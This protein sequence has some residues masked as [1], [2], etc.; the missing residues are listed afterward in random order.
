M[1]R[2]TTRTGLSVTATRLDKTYRT[3]VKV[4]P[5]DFKIIRLTRHTVC[6][7]LNYTIHPRPKHTE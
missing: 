4:S 2:T 1:R 3:G 7:K 5:A 6:P